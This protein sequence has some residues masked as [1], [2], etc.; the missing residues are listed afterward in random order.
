MEKIPKNILKLLT[1]QGFIEHYFRICFD[2]DTNRDAYE[3]VEELYQEWFTKR[4]YSNYE[5]FS[6]VKNRSLKK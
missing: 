5:S 1:K 2:Y 4:K 6:V 3:A